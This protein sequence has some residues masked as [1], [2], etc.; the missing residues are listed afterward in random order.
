[1]T[2]MYNLYCFYLYVRECV[3]IMSLMFGFSKMQDVLGHD[4][5]SNLSSGFHCSLLAFPFISMAVAQVA[6]TE[7]ALHL[8][9]TFVFREGIFNKYVFW[10]C[11]MAYFVTFVSI[12]KYTNMKRM[13]LDSIL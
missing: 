9:L 6:Y 3:C 12:N 1:M 4:S 10:H 5:L 13:S 11:A 8:I 2:S 7:A